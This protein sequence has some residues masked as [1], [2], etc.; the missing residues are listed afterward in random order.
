MKALEKYKRN[1]NKFLYKEYNNFASGS[2]IQIG[3]L[4]FVIALNCIVI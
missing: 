4:V 1:L 3:V 2:Q